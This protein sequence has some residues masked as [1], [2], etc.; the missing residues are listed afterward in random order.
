MR[1]AVG[2]PS[3]KC[4]VKANSQGR[5]FDATFNRLGSSAA[6]TSG[7]KL[8]PRAVLLNNESTP[9]TI[10]CLPF[11]LDLLLFPVHY[12]STF[13]I[14]PNTLFHRCSHVTAFTRRPCEHLISK[15]PEC[16]QSSSL[17]HL[18]FAAVRLHLLNRLRCLLGCIS[19]NVV[20]EAGITQHTSKQ[21]SILQNLA[22]ATCLSLQTRA[23]LMRLLPLPP[24]LQGKH[25]HL[26]SRE[27]PPPSLSSLDRAR[28][29][30]SSV[31][32]ETPL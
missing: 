17:L 26:G 2:Y 32:R 30:K 13:R 19:Q 5:Y 20:Q 15:T 10:Q 31:R 14:L 11:V 28:A 16:S 9:L 18:T 27:V 24:T 21:E 1:A 29:V 4:A 22:G 23:T 3:P 12:S 7:S 8:R 6:A 25:P